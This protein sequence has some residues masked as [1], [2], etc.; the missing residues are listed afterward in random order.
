MSEHID[1]ARLRRAVR[2]L[3]DPPQPPGWNAT[4]FPELWSDNT[5]LRQAAVL[6]PVVCRG[7][8]QWRVVG[9]QFR[10]HATAT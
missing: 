4:E 2:S 10:K 6:L 9:P 5:P 7:L 1:I 8:S 3:G